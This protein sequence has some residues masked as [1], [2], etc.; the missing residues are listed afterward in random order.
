MYSGSW[1]LGNKV[2]M[3]LPPVKQ[4][5]LH[6]TALSACP[7]PHAWGPQ[8]EVETTGVLAASSVRGR[9]RESVCA[10][11]ATAGLAGVSWCGGI[12]PGTLPSLRVCRWT[13]AGRWAVGS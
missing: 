3:G 12:F 2:G 7:C 5:I 8:W 4:V 1:E 10:A 9:Q 13:D 11:A 6:R